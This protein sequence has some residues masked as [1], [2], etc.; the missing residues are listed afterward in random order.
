[1]SFQYLTPAPSKKPGP[2]VTLFIIGGLVVLVV[3]AGLILLA[4]LVF[5]PATTTTTETV[6]FDIPT[7][8]DGY[9][10]AITIARQN[11]PAAILVSAAGAWAPNISRAALRAGRTGW[12]Y[13]IYLPATRQMAAIVVDRAGGNA[14]IASTQKWDTPPDVLD[15]T[16][17]AIDSW[18]GMTAFLQKCEGALNESGD[19]S[20]QAWLSTAKEGGGRLAWRYTIIA[21]D[22]TIICQIAVDAQTGQAQ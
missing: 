17:W 8:L 13:Y 21:P 4:V 11:D 5:R 22:E 14:R 16:T 1:M 6:S 2:P 15:D 18:Q 19:R 7:A 10:A 9:P 12:T 3:V 20:A